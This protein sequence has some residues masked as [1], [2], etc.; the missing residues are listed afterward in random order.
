[1]YDV[2][3]APT[4]YESGVLTLSRQ[5]EEQFP[6]DR[7]EL[8]DPLVRRG[9]RPWAHGVL[10][11]RLGWP[12]TPANSWKAA[13]RRAADRPGV[14]HAHYGPVGW[15]VVDAGLSPTVTSFYGFDTSEKQTLSEWRSAY[16]LLFRAG[17]AFIV[18]GPAMFERLV[19]LGAPPERTHVVPLVAV[20][21]DDWAPASVDESTP[22]RVLMSGRLVEKKGFADGVAAF[23]EA[24]R[25]GFDARLVVMGSGPEEG[26]IRAAVRAHGLERDVEFVPPQSR[27]RFREY[28]R[29]AQVFLQPS[30]TAS[31][32][33][34]EGTPATIL[35]A[36]S[37][38]RIVVTTRHADIPEVV[39]PEAAFLSPE[40]D[41]DALAASLAQALRNSDEWP[42]RGRAGRLL[43][44]ARHSPERIA[45]LLE[46]LYDE[47]ALEERSR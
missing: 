22:P 2:I 33:D 20:L 32:G 44:E 47:V 40:G 7:V 17:S 42:A 23:A 29:S 26:R 21:A 4:S 37:L 16:R 19:A 43:V 41:V 11:T 15:R 5:N 14:F 6:H 12:R 38:G 24:R 39:D 10:H 27:R 34:S 25:S 30:R 3:T 1:M 8:L 13:L 18:L 36:Q 46:R 35:D 28:L 31:D 9:S 45:G